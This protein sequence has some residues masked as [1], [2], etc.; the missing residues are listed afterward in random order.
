MTE[1]IAWLL[2]FISF[3]ALVSLWFYIVKKEL[4]KKLSAVETAAEQFN[5]AKI[6]LKKANDNLTS[7]PAQE[8]FIRSRNIYQQTISLYNRSLNKP[9]YKIPA[10]FL[11]FSKK[12]NIII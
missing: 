6:K 2:V 10:F 9:L 11:R 5:A 8:I 3:A 4:S 12:N 7:C 1:K